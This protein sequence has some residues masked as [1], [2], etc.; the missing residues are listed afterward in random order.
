[1]TNKQQRFFQ[2]A[3][4]IAATSLFPRIHIGA[5]IVKKNTV[6]AVG[7]NQQKS[8]PLQQR[9]NTYRNIP[10]ELHHYLHAEIAALVKTDEDLTEAEVYVYRENHND[11]LAMARPCAA[12]MDALYDRNVRTV[13]YTTNVGVATETYTVRIK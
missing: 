11:Q 12:C 8:H 3:Q 2:V 4:S 7:V 1:M 5:V 13:H 6:L 10:V 9:Y